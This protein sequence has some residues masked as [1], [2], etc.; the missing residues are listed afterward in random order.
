MALRSFL[1]ASLCL[2]WL[3]APVVGQT[4]PSK[5]TAATLDV[6][7]WNI[8]WFGASNGPS[9]DV[10]QRA[11]VRAVIEQADIDLWAVQEIAD[12]ADFNVLLS[13]LGTGFEGVLAT[14]SSQQ[15]IGFIYKTD[16]IQNVVT[17]HILTQF[18]HA[19]ATRP[20][21][22]LEADVIL[23][24]TTVR[25]TFITVHMK[26]FDDLDSYNRR[27]DASNRLK[28]HIDFL[29][30]NAPMVVLGDMNDELGRSI[31]AGRV[32]PYQNFLD[33]SAN[34]A[35]LTLPLDEQNIDTFCN[36]S[37]C[38]S[39]STLDHILIT[40][41]LFAAYEASSSARFDALLDSIT[42][43]TSST[44]DHLPV[45]ARFDF[46]TGTTVE[47]SD[48]PSA[49][50]VEPAYPNPFHATT[51]L[52]YTLSRPSPVEVAVFDLL[53]RRVA[54]LAEGIR[55]AGQHRAVWE[56]ATLPPGLYLLRLTTAEAIHTQGVVRVR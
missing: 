48:I 46:A 38:S 47:T 55:P 33:D 49:L 22:Q 8:E 50:M 54:T 42:G 40:D 19:F 1:Y 37:S 5:G 20:P 21:L 9:N 30:P 51:T 31:A 6:A 56:A 15:R 44:S 11:N 4:V 2:C 24:D 10:Q 43:Y 26:A 52:T 35:F 23:P 16:V 18:D 39:G 12:P 41:E 29:R 13:E 53:G 28:N 34:Y 45:F 27:V 32:S 3:T 17:G 7:T 36:N 14:E 25:M